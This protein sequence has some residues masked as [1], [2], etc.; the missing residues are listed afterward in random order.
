MV[1]IVMGALCA[2]SAFAAT[3]RVDS[4]SGFAILDNSSH[5]TSLVVSGVTRPIS[6]VTVSLYL[7]HT[8]DGDLNISLISPDGTS[9][10]LSLR[11]GVGDNFGV[12]ASPDASRTTFNDSA[13]TSI[14]A[15]VSPFVGSYKPQMPLSAF[16]GMQGTP[17]N[18][19]W[20]LRIADV[21]AGDQGIFYACSLSINTTDL[22]VPPTFATRVTL[23]GKNSVLRRHTYALSGSVAPSASSGQVKVVFKRYYSKA[24][25]QVGGAKYA[26]LKSGRFSLGYKPSTR[27]SWRAYVSYPGAVT[28]AAKYASAPTVYKQFKVK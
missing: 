24:W 5:D 2:S 17:V 6:A 23:S 4:S 11:N 3:T 13:L 16:A 9:V 20:R 21:S 1:A 19:T 7:T 25:R 12:A 14:T 10:D 28:A 27:G 18:G 15:G 26:T 22:P 8:Y